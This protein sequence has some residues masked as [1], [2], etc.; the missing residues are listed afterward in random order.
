MTMSSSLFKGKPVPSGPCL[1]AVLNTSSSP[2]ANTG[3]L[4]VQLWIHVR[5]LQ[6]GWREG[7][8]AP[9]GAS[10]QAAKPKAVQIYG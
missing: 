4:D 3:P 7:H 9:E 8:L 5:F 2:A 6:E 10:D 1:V